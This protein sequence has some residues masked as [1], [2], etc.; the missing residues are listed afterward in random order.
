MLG[1]L[2]AGPTRFSARGK[3]FSHVPFLGLKGLSYAAT[4]HFPWLA[5]PEPGLQ[6][7]AEPG[8]IGMIRARYVFSARV[9]RSV[10]GHRAVAAG[11]AAEAE[12]WLTPDPRPCRPRRHRVHLAYRCAV[13]LVIG[14]LLA[15][16]I[17]VERVSLA[18]GVEERA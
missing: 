3:I 13:A 4:S 7:V 6:R 17:E 5:C 9:R 1:L 14:S 10:G 15:A 11:G 2:L 12:G 18:D 8:G 16:E